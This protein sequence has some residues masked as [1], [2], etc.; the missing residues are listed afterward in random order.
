MKI[1]TGSIKV[2]IEKVI[3]KLISFKNIDILPIYG[4]KSIKFGTHAQIWVLA[5]NSVIFNLDK[6]SYMSSGDY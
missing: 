6:N 3:E 4:T 5:H 2:V 1:M